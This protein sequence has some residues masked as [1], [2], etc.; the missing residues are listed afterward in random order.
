M[1]GA[2]MKEKITKSLE[3]IQSLVAFIP[4][5]NADE[6]ETVRALYAYLSE[7]TKKATDEQELRLIE[8]EISTLWVKNPTIIKAVL[9]N[10]LVGLFSLISPSPDNSS[11]YSI[12]I[13][14]GSDSA[15]ESYLKDVKDLIEQVTNSNDPTFLNSKKREFGF[16]NKSVQIALIDG[17]ISRMGALP[18]P[19]STG[20]FSSIKSRLESPSEESLFLETIKEWQQDL[21]EPT[22]KTIRTIPLA[23][24]RHAV[25]EFHHY[26]QKLLEEKEQTASQAKVK[27]T[28]T[29]D[30]PTTAEVKRTATEPKS[31]VVKTGHKTV[32]EV[33]PIVAEDMREKLLADLRLTYS[34]L[35][36]NY[37][38]FSTTPQRVKVRDESFEDIKRYIEQVEGTNDRKTLA[39]IAN[40]LGF[41]KKSIQVA[42]LE[43]MIE[44]LTPPEINTPTEPSSKSV[45]EKV[46]TGLVGGLFK[47]KEK[48]VDVFSEITMPEKVEMQANAEVYVG[49][50]K[51]YLRQLEESTGK[52]YP[53]AGMISLGDEYRRLMDATYGPTPVAEVSP[54]VT[55]STT[56][57]RKKSHKREAV[58]ENSVVHER[59]TEELEKMRKAGVPEEKIKE[60]QKPVVIVYNRTYSADALEELR[61]AGVSQKRIDK[62]RERGMRLS[63]ISNLATINAK[64]I[65][66]FKGK[67]SREAIEEL[68][69]TKLS[70]KALKELQK[71]EQQFTELQEIKQQIEIEQGKKPGYYSSETLS[72]Y[73][74]K[75]AS[76]ETLDELSKMANL[77]QK[78]ISEFEKA[79]ISRE[80]LTTIQRGITLDEKAI[81]EFKS[82]GIT[83]NALKELQKPRF[84]SAT[85]DELQQRKTIN[86][87]NEKYRVLVRQ[88]TEKKEAINELLKHAAQTEEKLK[89]EEKERGLKEGKLSDDPYIQGRLKDIKKFNLEI[90]QQL[91]NYGKFEEE[92]SPLRDWFYRKKTNTTPIDMTKFNEAWEKYKSQDRQLPNGLVEKGKVT[93]TRIREVE[94]EKA[95]EYLENITRAYKGIDEA[96]RN[97]T[98]R[99]AQLDEVD[100]L[101]KSPPVSSKE[102]LTRIPTQTI[103]EAK[104]TISIHSEEGPLPIPT[105][106]PAVASEA[107]VIQNDSLA[108]GAILE[109]KTGK[110]AVRELTGILEEKKN[111]Y[112]LLLSKI[113]SM[114]AGFDSTLKSLEEPG[115]APTRE[116]ENATTFM[117]SIE[118]GIKTAKELLTGQTPSDSPVPNAKAE[119]SLKPQWS[120]NRELARLVKS[121]KERSA[122]FDEVVK[123][124]EAEFAQL[125]GSQS[126]LQLSEILQGQV[127]AIGNASNQL[128]EIKTELGKIIEG[129]H[130]E[131]EGTKK[132][133]QELIAKEAR[134][135]RSLVDDLE[136]LVSGIGKCSRYQDIKT[137]DLES[138]KASIKKTVDAFSD[139]RMR[140][141]KIASD[142]KKSKEVLT[143]LKTELEREV[144]TVNNT[145]LEE[146]RKI[147]AL[148]HETNQKAEEYR[149]AV[150]ACPLL[151]P[152]GEGAKA[153][154][155]GHPKE[156]ANTE[157]LRRQMSKMPDFPQTELKALSRPNHDEVLTYQLP[158]QSELEQFKRRVLQRTSALEAET[159][160]VKELTKRNASEEVSIV[161]QMVG[162]VDTYLSSA[163]SVVTTNILSK[164]KGD[165][166][167]HI[168]NYLNLEKGYEEPTSFAA[169][170]ITAM[171]TD[172]NENNLR[173]LS[174]LNDF[175]SWVQPFIEKVLSGLEW[176][177]SLAV[178]PQPKTYRPQFFAGDTEKNVAAAAQQAQE[179]LDKFKTQVGNVAPE[180][181]VS[182][183]PL[184]ATVQ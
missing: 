21:N 179:S 80:T 178:T 122:E 160:K 47:A 100:A 97:I 152:S 69:E 34:L 24:L 167:N 50:L 153:V 138:I 14:E 170:C 84:S 88:I 150:S 128:E 162:T 16:L 93:R 103:R 145:Y 174:Q 165:L 26:H 181:P 90:Q 108:K 66:E 120:E 91:E 83:P 5:E 123:R 127:Q 11:A 149:E 82:A 4:E 161:R 111:S 117:G 142:A 173:Q 139:E 74:Q 87:L 33:K 134:E 169:K 143:E 125:S 95:E 121:Y 157:D 126:Q 168:L 31:T 132:K 22:T 104:S 114:T 9:L 67:V 85:L 38:I 76:K 32:S 144:A 177:L 56:K 159:L 63:D 94:V 105:E 124:K 48:I 155:P 36:S 46:V 140:A 151:Q 81:G 30:K 164:V 3:Q 147:I 136:T 57:A 68:H 171:Q 17:M 52:V 73:Q 148:L 115:L 79:G 72:E 92:F 158:S 7:K 166:N 109:E 172:L 183:E 106:I 42:F 113:E 61:I 10:N 154:I 182:R 19:R 130:T 75:V 28:V 118:K 23:K 29:K 8:Q 6:R 99:L 20:L 62:F 35:D 101:Q 71:I 43:G 184:K 137:P 107:E 49:T 86:E 13:Q 45:A 175:K 15:R 2:I 1:A 163:D 135:I 133:R 180:I 64:T 77:S 27:P 156:I 51:K 70:M 44:S 141:T 112:G 89:T 176:L 110:Q 119:V 58:I 41:I 18:S 78:T 55:K 116:G 37:S 25:K 59:S 146:C 12:F 60:L 102:T 40:D 131:I 54:T 98:E 129:I 53:T 65:N 39:Q 96:T